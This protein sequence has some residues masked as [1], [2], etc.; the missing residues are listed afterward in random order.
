MKAMNIVLTLKL[1]III[2][3]ASVVV[4]AGG[5]TAGVILTR[6]DA[7]RV[8][9]VFELTGSATVSREAAGD[10][11]AY[12]GM[13]LESGD[14]L[15]V[16]EDSIMRLS[17]DNDKYILL[18]SGT[19]LELIAAGTP[20]DSR[21]VINLKEGTILNEITNSLSANSSYE[22]NTPKAT[23]A[24]RGTSFSVTVE[25]R[26]NSF[27]TDLHT[28]HGRVSVQLIGEDGV[29]KGKEVTVPED[30]CVTIITDPNKT[31]GNDPTVDGNSYFV[32]RSAEDKDAYEP[33][34]EGTDP[35][36]DSEYGYV[37]GNILAR[38]LD[39]DSNGTLNISDGV[40][41]RILGGSDVSYEDNVNGYTPAPDISDD[42]EASAE[43]T[44]PE[45]ETYSVTTAPVTEKSMTTPAVTAGYSPKTVVMAVNNAVTTVTES[46]T[47]ASS[48]AYVSTERETEAESMSSSE[49]DTETET[50]AE[51]T[52][53]A[54]TSSETAKETAEETV[55]ETVQASSSETAATTTTAYYP[56]YTGGSAT[57][58]Q[59]AS[60]PEETAEKHTLV[61]TAEIPGEPKYTYE[62]TVEDGETLG[63]VPELP[64]RTGY[65]G[66]WITDGTDSEFTAETVITEDMTFTAVY[67]INTYTVTFNDENDN[68]LYTRTAEY[69]TAVSNFPDVP[70]KTGYSGKWVTDS[71][72]EFTASTAVTENMTVKAKY[73]IETYTVTFNDENGNELY[74]RTAE[75]NTAVSNFP[76]VPDKTGYTGK[77][78]T[79]SGAEFIASTAVTE[80]MTVK[81]DYSINSYTVTFNDENDNELYT[82][83]ADYNTAVSNFPDVP[84]KTG[85]TGKW[86][87]DSGAEF[88]ASTAVT[89][90]MTVKADYS[91][92][93]YTVT[94]NDENGNELYTRTAVYNTAVSNFPAVP[95]KTGSTGK[96]VTDS[97]A[98]FTAS[99]AVTENMTVK[100]KYDI[101]TYT[102][103]FNDENGNELYTRTAEY[104]TTISDIPALPASVGS[105]GEWVYYVYGE[106]TIQYGAKFDSATP[107]IS[108]MTVTAKIPYT[109]TVDFGG[110]TETYTVYGGDRFEL[111]ENPNISSSDHTCLYYLNSN[112]NDTYSPGSKVTIN[113]DAYFTFTVLIT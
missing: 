43:D 103:T 36:Y 24:V 83:T 33:V 58:G 67:T 26:G 56:Q 54:E 44:A 17:L 87:T 84:D 16:G 47:E 59:T 5:V 37:S 64:L 65:S 111:P 31:T 95:D 74:T 30:K 28:Y 4:V 21:T 102:V 32:I 70:D 109:V 22:V 73:D 52:E 11:D 96:W 51:T 112:Y 12:V 40:I 25:K 7:Y 105:M 92:N 2:A 89:E 8:L 107:V 57:T 49:D 104:N 63:F 14:T 113:G 18:D 53:T 62:Y 1:K 45:A 78:V 50:S 3:V 13:N 29:P 35:V 60:E 69:N 68:E 77:W 9:K 48:S 90:S 15:T 81:A 80:N 46:V 110:S 82:R 97:G 101:K 88:T 76:A 27:S 42:T 93:S 19:V 91:I 34:P 100:A 20:N 72:A 55:T 41:E 98:E 79:D 99:T 94:F 75:Y 85:S 61:F 10:L 66:K 38:V 86:V 39:S 23:M 71:G 108:D 106:T 6:E